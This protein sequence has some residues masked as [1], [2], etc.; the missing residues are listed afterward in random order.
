MSDG[1]LWGRFDKEH[2]GAELASE[3]A[4]G[5]VCSGSV[6]LH[7]MNPDSHPPGQCCPEGGRT[8]SVPSLP[9]TT[10]MHRAGRSVGQ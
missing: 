1:E 5:F 8:T 7:H 6:T 3:D 10:S 2:D 4:F 9:P